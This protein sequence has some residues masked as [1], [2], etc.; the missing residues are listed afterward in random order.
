[1]ATTGTW[2]E[3]RDNRPIGLITISDGDGSDWNGV[4]TII[5]DTLGR[6][7][8]FQGSS[9]TTSNS[10]TNATSYIC[11][12]SGITSN[13]TS[14]ATK[15]KDCIN[16]AN[17]NGDLSVKAFQDA[18]TGAGLG[19]AGSV[20]QG[21]YQGAGPSPAGIFLRQLVVPQSP[22]GDWQTIT[23]TADK[24]TVRRF[25]RGLVTVAR[26]DLAD[27]PNDD[28]YIKPGCVVTPD[29]ILHHYDLEHVDANFNIDG[30]FRRF[31]VDHPRQAPF[32]KRFQLCRTPG[33]D[34]SIID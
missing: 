27:Y 15:F 32:S 21:Y 22:E 30:G 1:M 5:T 16:L 34:R 18:T 33:G 29:F 4:T 10:R 24:A 28:L 31:G 7:V 26:S 17:A 11:G 25:G 20:A 9:G 2:T 12:F 14:I 3:Y 13:T 19:G 8:T 6:T 23:H